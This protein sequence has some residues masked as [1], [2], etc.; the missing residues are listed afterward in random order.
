MRAMHEQQ[1]RINGGF[2]A[3]RSEIFNYIREGEELVEQPSPGSSPRRS[4]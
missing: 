2:F 1:L 4:S 3:L